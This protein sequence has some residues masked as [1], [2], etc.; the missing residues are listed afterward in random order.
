MAAQA[1]NAPWSAENVLPRTPFDFGGATLDLED[2]RD[3][4]LLQF[5]LSQALYGEAT[6]VY[7]GKSLYACRWR[8]R[9]SMCGRR[10]RS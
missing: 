6:G 10:G 5:V 8:R 7:C 1:E 3:R 2:A 4:A 9:A